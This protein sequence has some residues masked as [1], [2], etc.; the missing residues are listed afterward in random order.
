MWPSPPTMSFI[1]EEAENHF[2]GT[3]REFVPEP[4]IVSFI[5]KVT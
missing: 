2:S 1:G 5:Q 4:A 3:H